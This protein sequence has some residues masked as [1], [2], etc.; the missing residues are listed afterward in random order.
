MN[1]GTRQNL[2]N[3]H[4]I[5][6]IIDG[7]N[8]SNVE[9]QKLLGIIIDK[10]LS[11]DSQIDSVCQKITRRITLLKVLSKYVDKSSLKQYYNSYILP[12]FDYGCMI[13]GQCSLYNMI[14]LFK[15][16]KR[17]AR[18]I[19]HADYMTPSQLMFQELGWL[20]FPKRIQYHIGVMVFKSLNGLAPEYLTNLLTKPSQMHGRNLRSNDKE[21]LKIPFSRTT[22]YDKSFSVTGPR[23]WNSLPLEL[24]QSSHLNSFIKA[25]KS[26]L[27]HA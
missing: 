13:W 15:L 26:Y 3:V 5:N 17:A 22:Y 27:L 12:I 23:F 11:W 21:I 2:L 19:L 7:E 1:I 9:N 24:R 8:I 18:T 10:T 16:Q 14:R 4:D 6:I 20:T 25:L